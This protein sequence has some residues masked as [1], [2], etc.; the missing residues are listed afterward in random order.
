MNA[1]AASRIRRRSSPRRWIW[2]SLWPSTP[3]PP[4]APPPVPSARAPS[5]AQTGRPGRS[6]REP[7][8]VRRVPEATLPRD[9]TRRRLDALTLGLFTVA[10]GT[11]VP[12]PL[13]LIYRRTLDL[14][15]A[16][17]TAIFGCYAIGL[18]AALTLAVPV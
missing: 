12:T 14:S 6:G 1:I 11:N 10:L 2:P 17:L 18:I 8:S 9:P 13:L 4:I 3:L 5:L 15:A 7:G 16:D